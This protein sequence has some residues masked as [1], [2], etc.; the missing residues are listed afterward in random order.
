MSVSSR[1]GTLEFSQS[2]DETIN[3]SCHGAGTEQ[4]ANQ[5]LEVHPKPRYSIQILFLLIFF[6]VLMNV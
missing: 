3:P 4:V 5:S 6:N 1:L 2:P